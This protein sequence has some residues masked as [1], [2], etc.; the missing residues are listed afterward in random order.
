MVL[1][2]EKKPFDLSK[3]SGLAERQVFENLPT[4]PDISLGHAAEAL[5]AAEKSAAALRLPEEAKR[6]LADLVAPH[7]GCREQLAALSAPALAMQGKMSEMS[8]LAK[9]AFEPFRLSAAQQ[10]GLKAIYASTEEAH[11]IAK[12]LQDSV[13]A[14][15][16][17]EKER[18]P[19]VPPLIPAAAPEPRDEG[20]EV[21]QEI[22]GQYQGKKRELA[23]NPRKVVD[24]IVRFSDG[25]ALFVRQ[26]KSEGG[27][28]ITVTGMDRDGETRTLRAGIATLTFEVV[29]I[30]VEPSPPALKVVRNEGEDA[31]S[32]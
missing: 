10:E 30:D 14:F 18:S 6:A 24:V 9:D 23:D 11:R 28:T 8:R 2:S 13:H 12:S 7:E 21:I 26:M 5:N 3:L 31:D 15:T 17:R 4:I 25:L 16:A 22:Y 29:V 27:Q 19:F 1:V 32:D 20:R